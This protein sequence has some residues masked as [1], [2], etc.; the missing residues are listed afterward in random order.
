[1][2]VL[3]P[4]ISS[5]TAIMQDGIYSSPAKLFITDLNVDNIILIVPSEALDITDVRIPTFEYLYMEPKRKKN[6][7]IIFPQGD[8]E[9][10]NSVT[11]TELLAWYDTEAPAHRLRR[12][13]ELVEMNSRALVRDDILV[14]DALVTRREYVPANDQDAQDY[15]KLYVF[16]DHEADLRIIVVKGDQTNA[17]TEYGELYTG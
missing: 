8:S 11:L 9:Q 17:G 12:Y 14:N 16:T 2:A 6:T 5:L 15:T 7:Q 3:N 1:M 10:D 4:F 13:T